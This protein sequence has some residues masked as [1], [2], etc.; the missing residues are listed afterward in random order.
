[1]SSVRAQG[2]K[3]QRQP[4]VAVLK[5]GASEG[6]RPGQTDTPESD[7]M[8]GHLQE[9]RKAVMGGVKRVSWYMEFSSRTMRVLWLGLVAGTMGLTQSSRTKPNTSSVR[10]EAL[11]SRTCQRR[12][13]TSTTPCSLTNA[14]A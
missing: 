4:A 9:G 5:Q 12:L 8:D 11:T 1:M 10:T 13:Q 2:S 14:V 6:E 7:G 3:R